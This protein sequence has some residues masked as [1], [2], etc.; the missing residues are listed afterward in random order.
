MNTR[1][2]NPTNNVLLLIDLQPQM[3]FAVGSIEGTLLI[4]NAVGLA[5]SAML[6]KIPTLITTIAQ[7]TFSGPVFKQLTDVVHQKVEV[8]RTFINSWEDNRV[9]DFVAK[10]GRKKVV[11]AGLWTEACITFPALMALEQGYEVYVVV[12]ACGGVTPTVHE[13]AVERMVQAGATP[14]TWL[15]YLLELQRDWARQE[16]YDGVMQIAIEHAGS[17]G[18]GIQYAHAMLPSQK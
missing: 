14:I 7:K 9:V 16:T 10:T 4:N 12:D 15:Q 18:M 11:L 17:Y 6:F 8:D 13:A 5:K 2:L 3:L 1:L